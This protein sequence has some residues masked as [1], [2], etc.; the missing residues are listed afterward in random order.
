M[1]I[2]LNGETIET[3]TR[4]LDELCGTLGYEKDA[5]IATAVNGE[6]VPAGRRVELQLASN[7]EIE[8][9]APRQGG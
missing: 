6:F 5:K 4:T 7:D 9:V 8:I 2:R 3:A 1:N